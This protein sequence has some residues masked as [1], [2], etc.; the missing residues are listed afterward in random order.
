[1]EVNKITETIVGCAIEVHKQLWPDLLEPTYEACL[2]H[3][4]LNV[5]LNGQRQLGL[6]LIYKETKL[7]QGY[8]LDLLVE[9]CIVA[10]I[11][12]VE[13]I[14]DIHIAQV[15]TYLKLS[16]AKVGLIINF[17]VLKLTNGIKRLIARN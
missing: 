3:E 13:V 5:G 7:E 10:E 14:N 15:L 2:H 11:K 4:L 6:P 1:M 12:T 16:D 9:D 8:R 17:D